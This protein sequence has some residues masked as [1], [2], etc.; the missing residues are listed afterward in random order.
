MT[1]YFSGQAL[2]ILDYPEKFG[3]D[4]HLTFIDKKT[5]GNRSNRPEKGTHSTYVWRANRN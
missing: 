1:S 5:N 2:K 4:G 3:T